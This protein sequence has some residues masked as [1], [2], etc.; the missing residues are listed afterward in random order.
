MQESQFF[1]VS[2][3]NLKVITILV[4]KI[5]YTLSNKNQSA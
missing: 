1:C 2:K 3:Q 5:M 4:E